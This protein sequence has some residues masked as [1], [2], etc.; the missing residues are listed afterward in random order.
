MKIKANYSSVSVKGII[1]AVVRFWVCERMCVAGD[2]SRV[3]LLGWTTA[4]AGHRS[5]V[6]GGCEKMDGRNFRIWLQLFNKQIDETSWVG[7]KIFQFYSIKKKKKK[8]WRF[9]CTV[10]LWQ[11]P[12]TSGDLMKKHFIH[13]NYS[14][15]IFS[16]CMWSVKLL[17]RQY[18]LLSWGHISTTL[19]TERLLTQSYM[20]F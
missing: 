18:L 8:S 13:F 15:L 7:S 17:L 14:L 16:I 19:C 3:F 2:R 4:P 10:R 20:S 9:I 1:T 11:D 5:G 6:K 12:V